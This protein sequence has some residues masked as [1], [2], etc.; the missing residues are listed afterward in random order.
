MIASYIN[1]YEEPI[2]C[3]NYNAGQLGL[4]SISTVFLWITLA[5]PFHCKPVGL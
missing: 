4:I 5:D 1:I 2:N 3:F